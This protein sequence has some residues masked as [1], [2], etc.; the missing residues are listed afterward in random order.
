MALL[1]LGIVAGGVLYPTSV[2]L[3]AQKKEAYMVLSIGTGVMIGLSSLILGR[4]FG[5]IGAAERV[6]QTDPNE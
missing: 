4:E 2:Y 1:L 3:R 6:F 5:A